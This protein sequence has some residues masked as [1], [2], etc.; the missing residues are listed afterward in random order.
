MTSHVSSYTYIS[1]K[2]IIDAHK[3]DVNFTSN[4]EEFHTY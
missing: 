3:S 2:Y 1:K 4:V